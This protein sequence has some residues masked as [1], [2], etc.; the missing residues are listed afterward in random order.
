MPGL[1]NSGMGVAATALK[2]VLSYAQL[3]SGPAGASGTNN[4]T[5]A[6]RQAVSWGSTTGAG[7]FGLAS[8][9]D[10]T[11]GASNGDIY[12]VTLWSSSTG[13]TFY[14]EFVIAGDAAF[15]SSGD[16]SLTSL[17]LDGSAA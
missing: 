12:S 2:A 15:N 17:S 6:A 3:H 9:L 5:T 11:G 13:G 10:F 1:N 7:D 8:Q 4:V 16:Y 14:G